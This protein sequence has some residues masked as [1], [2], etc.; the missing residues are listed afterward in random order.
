[1]KISFRKKSR[2]LIGIASLLLILFLTSTVTAQIVSVGGRVIDKE[3]KA[4]LPGVTVVLKGKTQGTVTDMDGKFQIQASATDQ[5]IFSYIGYVSQTISLD[6]RTTI[7]VALAEEVKGLDE[8]VVIGYGTQKKSDLTGAVASIDAGDIK[9][10]TVRG[11]DQALQGRVAGVQVTQNSGS[12]GSPITVRI[13]GIGTTDNSDP[14]YVVDGIAVG[15]IG[16]LNPNDIEKIDILKD[17]SAAAIYGAA[18]ANGV[19]LITTKQGKSGKAVVELNMSYGVQN[20]YHQYG[21]TNAEENQMLSLEA[22]TNSRGKP[23]GSIYWDKTKKAP[24]EILYNTNWQDE[25]AQAA[26]IQNYH[27]SISGGNDNSQYNYSL[28]YF[29]QKGIIINSGFERVT[30]RMNTR[31]K[32]TDNLIFGTNTTF[33]NSKKDVSREADEYGPISQ[34][35]MMDPGTPVYDQEN[36]QFIWASGPTNIVNPVRTLELTNDRIDGNQMVS[37]IFMEWDIMAGLKFKTIAG[38]NINYSDRVIF[39]P[40]YTSSRADQQ[41][42]ISNL[43]HQFHKS[44]SLSSENTLQYNKEFGKHNL[45]ALLGYTVFDAKGS[46]NS[47]IGL[48]APNDINMREFNAISDKS[49]TNARL[50]SSWQSKGISYLS[51]II[52]SYADKY[53]LTASVR[54]DGSSKF[55]KA[56]RFGTFPSASFGWKISNEEFMKD[57]IYISSLKLRAGWGSIGNN[58]IPDYAYT[59]LMSTAGNLAYSF[60]GIGTDGKRYIG[61]LPAGIANPEVHWEESVQKNIGVDASFFDNRISFTADYFI[62]NTMGMLLPVEV[63]AIVGILSNPII[64]AGNI[65]NKGFEFEITH[66]KVEGDFTYSI[67]ANLTAIKNEVIELG[68]EGA[69]ILDGN[70]KGIGSVSRTEAGHPIASFY[71]FKTDGIF[72]SQDEINSSATQNA[73]TAPG[74]V[75]FVDVNGDKKITDADQTYIGS[76]LPKFTYGGNLNC[77]YK[78]IDLAVFIQ[79]SYGNQVY[80]GM[81]VMTSNNFNNYNKT[82]LERWTADNPSTTVPRV[83]L[84]DANNNA[85]NSDRWVEDASYMRIK[86]IQLGYALPSSVLNAIKLQA[87]RIYIAADNLM[88]FTKYTGLDPEVGLSNREYGHGPLEIGLDRGNYPQ[89]RTLSA[90]LNITF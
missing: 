68:T 85:R 9:N 10:V 67:S 61:S 6:G 17:A 90:G 45:T 63:P 24:K 42:T 3:S 23:D 74:D 14:L 64:N 62:K 81:A 19:V 46:G 80:N 35:I 8:V 44:M 52:Y 73:K 41:L 79:G 2:S 59:T 26:P 4:T 29:G 5:L 56:N 72:Q 39:N 30:A 32:I 71:G 25:I 27:L 65:E 34:A 87:V 11:V 53:L 37:N 89:A 16:F 75:K 86:N 83:V 57:L 20:M 21:V 88:T 33:S 55:G 69:Y 13:R 70:M 60:G 18:A 84:S 82:M 66:R 43:E 47:V 31:S 22:A 38:A 36:P 1:M 7:E 51:R 28:G 40:T 54:R 76:P 50:G 78:G 15:G 49:L 58:Q 77:A 12:P 48:G